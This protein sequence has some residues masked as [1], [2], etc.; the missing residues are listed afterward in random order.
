M[1][2]IFDDSGSL[3]RTMTTPRVLSVNV[4]SI[5]EIEWRGEIVTTGIWKNPVAGRVVLSGV[6][7]AGDDQADRTVHGGPDKAVYA[8]ACEDYD[9]W[10]EQRGL[11]TP[12]GLFGENLT[13]QG[14]DL[15]SALVGERWSVGSTLLEVAQPRLPCYKLGIR[16]G[17]PY[18]PK[19]FLQAQR[20]GAYFRVIEE[21]DVGAGDDVHVT[22]RPEH[23][24]TL[25]TMTEALRDREKAARLLA[26]D[27]LPAFWRRLAADS[28]RNVAAPPEV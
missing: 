15:S 21:G 24:V 17:D 7:F 27:R 8:Y 22:A 14:I 26:V 23:G 25:R 9:F 16:M 19:R 12:V 11:E 4:G 18:F 1:A 3:T 2:K 13:V 28:G 6:N 10:R 20:M 5:R